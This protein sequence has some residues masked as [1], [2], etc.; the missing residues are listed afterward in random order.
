MIIPETCE[1]ARKIIEESELSSGSHTGTPTDPTVPC[2]ECVMELRWRVLAACGLFGGMDA[3]P[4]LLKKHRGE[5][6]L[7]YEF[8]RDGFQ[9]AVVGGEVIPRR[10]DMPPGSSK[11]IGYLLQSWNDS[12]TPRR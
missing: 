11:V 12:W 6:N 2:E 4:E 8:D 3:P 5:E 1:I 7:A 9:Y 10:S